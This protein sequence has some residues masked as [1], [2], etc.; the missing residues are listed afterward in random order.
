MRSTIHARSSLTPERFRGRRAEQRTL[1]PKGT[2]LVET[3]DD[4]AFPLEPTEIDGDR[5]LELLRLATN[6]GL[7]GTSSGDARCE[8]CA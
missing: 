7:R 1:V 6:A 2:Y 5:S 3:R 4:G 8:H